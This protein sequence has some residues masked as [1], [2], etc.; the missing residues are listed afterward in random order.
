MFTEATRSLIGYAILLVMAGAAV[1]ALLYKNRS[2]I[3]EIWSGICQMTA[4]TVRLRKRLRT[5]PRMRTS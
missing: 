2:R 5:P 1:A 4:E 3:R